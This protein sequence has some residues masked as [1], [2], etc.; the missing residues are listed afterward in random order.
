MKKVLI[1]ASVVAALSSCGGGSSDKPVDSVKADSATS[2]VAPT[3]D[4]TATVDST[5]KADSAK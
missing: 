3:V 1:L 4:S 2:T 5:V